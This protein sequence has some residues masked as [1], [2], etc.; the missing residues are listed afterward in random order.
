MRRLRLRRASL[1]SASTSSPVMAVG[2]GAVRVMGG[3]VLD[4]SQDYYY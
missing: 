3:L 1:N 2:R 4:A